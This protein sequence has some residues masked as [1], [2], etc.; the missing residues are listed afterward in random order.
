M[1]MLVGYVNYLVFFS[2]QA[3]IFAVLCLGL[4]VQ[5]GYTGL[6]NI[7]IAGFYA[8]GAY[9]SA[10]VSGLPPAATDLRVVGGLNLPFGVGLVAAMVVS[11]IVAFIISIPV[12]RLKEDYLAIATIGIAEVIR[13]VLQN[14]AWLS[15]GVWGIKQIPAPLADTIRPAVEA[16]LGR[17]PDFSGWLN[18]LISNGYNWFYLSLVVLVLVAIYWLLNRLMESPWGRVLKAIREDEV[19]ASFAGKDVFW[20]KMQSM[21]VGSMLMGAAG[22]LYAHFATFINANTFEPMFGTF[23]I[24]V[25]LIVG[26]SGSNRGAIVGAFAVWM[27]WSGSDFISGFVNLQGYQSAALR[28]LLVAVLLEVMLLYKPQGLMGERRRRVPVLPA[29]EPAET[30]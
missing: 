13:M 5:W 9:T 7:G 25:M 16:F 28:I 12:L 24:W 8:V 20:F 10:L 22:A 18:R 2:I 4:N 11:G 3:G 21:V 29:P 30:D 6:F 19:V 17:H 1:D 15:N 14:E 27:I 23:L 26:G